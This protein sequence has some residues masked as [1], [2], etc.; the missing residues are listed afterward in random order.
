[1]PFELVQLRVRVE[2]PGVGQPSRAQDG[3][4]VV[5]GEPDGRPR[6]L[7]RP[8]GELLLVQP[9]AVPLRGHHLALEQSSYDVELLLEH[10]Q[11]LLGQPECVVLLLAVAEPEAEHE[12]TLGDGVERGRGLRDL[13]RIEQ[14]QQ[15]DAGADAHLPRLGRMR[16]SRGTSCRIWNGC[17]RRCCTAETSSK[18]S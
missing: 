18:P 4:V 15:E 1:M 8:Q 11:A 9:E 17:V 13:D 5:R 7:R 3:L 6:A 2:Q 14:R 12:A 16:A 10:A